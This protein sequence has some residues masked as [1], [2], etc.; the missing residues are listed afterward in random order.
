MD[1]LG[2]RKRVGGQ[3]EALGVQ[4]ILVTQL[5][6]V[7]YLTG[8]SGSNGQVLVTPGGGGRFFTD[9]RYIEQS[10]REVPDLER[11][12]YSGVFAEPLSAACAD[13]G[14]ESLAFEAAGLSFKTHSDL[15]AAVAAN[16]TPVNGVVEALRW[17]K[18]AGELRAIR[19]AQEITDAAFHAIL[20]ALREGMTERKV[21]RE[22][23]RLMEEAGA[24]ALAFDT[25]AAFGPSAAEPHHEP[26]DRPLAQGEMVKLDFGA[27]SDGYHAD[28]T[29]TVALGEPSS[30]LREIYDL[31]HASQLAGIAA[32]RPGTTGAEVDRAAR[33]V[34]E[35]AGLG[36]EFSHGLGHGV[37]LEIHEGPT[38]RFT[39]SDILPKGSVVT[40]EP[41]IYRAGL[42]GVR[43]E[44]MVEV[45]EDGCLPMPTSTK[46]LVIL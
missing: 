44:D 18:D 35:E 29:R 10:R 4:A 28:M 43:I 1:H 42:G 45:T 27:V 33:T 26:T 6:N 12:I 13:L 30:A 34:I 15:A 17:V 20:P 16:F 9:G 31:V 37:G 36:E 32:V 21:A 11:V 5:P 2:R 24:D 38:V 40:I 3:L 19:N 41:G 46:E 25:I 23:R 7:R 8:Y 14:I 22:L 39:S